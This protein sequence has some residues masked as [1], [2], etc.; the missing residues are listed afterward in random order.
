MSTGM[1]LPGR[2]R[3]SGDSVSVEALHAV[4]SEGG[5]AVLKALAAAEL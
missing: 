3:E 2:H 4:E 5:H 1:P